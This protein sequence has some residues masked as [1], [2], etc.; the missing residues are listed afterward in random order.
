T[1]I[2]GD[3]QLKFFLLLVGFFFISLHFLY[4]AAKVPSRKVL[5]SARF[6]LTESPRCLVFNFISYENKCPSPD[7]S[8]NPFAFSFKK[9]KIAADSGI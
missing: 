7:S 8:G 5:F 3:L 6:D 2:T 9:Q 1:L 4:F